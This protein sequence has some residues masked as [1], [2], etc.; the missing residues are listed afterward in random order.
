[1][2]ETARMPG[3]DRWSPGWV[4]HR[5]LAIARAIAGDREPLLNFLAHGLTSD[6]TLAASLNYW[7]AW[8]GDDTTTYHSDEFMAGDLGSWRGDVLL[9]SL[10]RNLTSQTAYLEMCIRAVWAL[11][12]RRPN[13]LDDPAAAADLRARVT[14][15]L[16]RPSEIVNQAR[17]DLQQI[18]YILR[19]RQR[20]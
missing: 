16:D 11:L 15:L 9:A 19:W 8:C 4:L 20:A 12:A 3:L 14:D 7:A 18:N 13:L 5:S 2:A 17:N 1:M 6:E 10:T